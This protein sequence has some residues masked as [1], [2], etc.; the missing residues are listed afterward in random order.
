MT[1]T[2]EADWV[3][4]GG[5]SAGSVLAAR[6]SE[7]PAGE[8]VLLEAGRDWRSADAPPQLRSMNGWRALD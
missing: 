8:V 7:D 2:V 4:V 1:P 6:L 3:V 5:G